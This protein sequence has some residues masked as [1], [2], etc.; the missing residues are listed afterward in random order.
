MSK[1]GKKQKGKKAGG[2]PFAPDGKRGRA[3]KGRAEKPEPPALEDRLAGIGSRSPVKWLAHPLLLAIVVFIAAFWVRYYVAHFYAKGP[4]N[5]QYLALAHDMARGDYFRADFDLDRGLANSR[6][7]VPF[8]PALVAVGIKLGADAEIA[9][10]WISVF[11]GALTVFPL[12]GIGLRISNRWGGM[13]AG[14]L[15]AS[16]PLDMQTAG[17]VLTESTFN[18]CTAAAVFSAMWLADRPSFGRAALAGLV[19]ALSYLTRDI[20]LGYILLLAVAVIISA[21]VKKWEWKRAALLI[22]A[23]FIVFFICSTPYWIFIKARTGSFNLTLRTTHSLSTDMMGWDKGSRP[24]V[25]ED[26]GAKS[27]ATPLNPF[28]ALSK[29]FRLIWEYNRES[30]NYVPWPFYVFAAAGLVLLPWKERERWADDAAVFLWVMGT[31]GAYALITPYMVDTRYYLPAAV[32]AC[33]W[34]GRGAARLPVT[35]GNSAPGNQGVYVLIAAAALSVAGLGYYTLLSSKRVKYTHDFYSME[36]YRGKT[37]SGHREIAE[38]TKKILGIEPG[39]RIISRK[40]YFAYY[41]DSR[42]VEVAESVGGVRKQV[43]NLEGDYVFVGSMC[44]RRY[45]PRLKELVAAIDPLPGAGLVYRRYLMDYNKLFSVYQVGAN[46]MK[47]KDAVFEGASPTQIQ[48]ALQKAIQYREQGYVEHARQILQSII[49]LQP[50]NAIAHR[51]MVMVYMAYGYFDGVSLDRAEDELMRYAFLAPSA[52]N[53][54][55]YKNSI[56]NLRVQHQAQWGAGR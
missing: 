40:P 9:G 1:K 5:F 26:A 30:S 28:R 56:Q 6:R 4:D 51:E 45:R 31:M 52:R 43:G 22:G 41:L 36:N 16:L 23:S 21:M 10:T 13:A 12:F 54:D 2:K 50:D 29:T 38:D 48:S 34:A 24:R 44:V 19:A 11:L 37:V 14:I 55:Y 47:S 53:I 25:S 3:G 17:H 18:F 49:D 46:P 32:V 20:G 27:G 35:V 42:F 7:V 33:A 39:S 8:Y 15:Y